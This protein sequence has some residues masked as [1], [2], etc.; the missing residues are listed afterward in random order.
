MPFSTV[1]KILLS[2]ICGL[3]IFSHML[4]AEGLPSVPDSPALVNKGAFLFNRL[5]DTSSLQNCA[6]CHNITSV[7]TFNWNPSALEIARAFKD[8]SLDELT[9]ALNDPFDWVMME[10]HEGYRFKQSEAEAI[11]AYLKFI[12]DNTGSLKSEKRN[13]AGWVLPILVLLIIFAVRRYKRSSKVISKLIYLSFILAAIFLGTNILLKEVT[14]F[15]RQQNYR[16]T[17][18]VKFSHRLHVAENEIDCY[19]CHSSA[20]RSRYAGIPSNTVCLNCHNVVLEGQNSGTWEIDKLY[21]FQQRQETVHWVKVHNLP[22]HVFFSH[23]QH[24][25]VAKLT[26]AECHGKVEEMHEIRQVKDLSMGWCLD[27]HRSSRVDINDGGY[28]EVTYKK[29]RDNAVHKGKESVSLKEVGGTDCM[30]CHY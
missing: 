17:Q 11:H 5:N 8:K 4:F 12:A 27:C 29:M 9:E 25:G 22:D 2:L 30:K 21:T 7:D 15:G 19:Y 20:E 1:P 18:P 26:C 24:V 14:N 16:P 6:V 10:K 13:P 3:G 23:A 28:Y